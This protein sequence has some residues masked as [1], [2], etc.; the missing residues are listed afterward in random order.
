MNYSSFRYYYPPRPETVVP[1]ASLPLFENKGYIWQ[2]KLNGSCALIFTNGKEVRLMSRHKDTFTYNH[3]K[4]EEMLLLQR[5]GWTVLAGE[6]MNKGQKGFDGKVFNLKFVIWD[7]LVHSGTYLIGTT[8][9]YR[10]E[11]IDTLYPSTPYDGWI[12]KVSENIYKAKCFTTGIAKMYAE[13]IKI[14][15]YE[16][17]VGKKATAKLEMG[18]HA[19]NNRGWM[20][21]C[22]K[23][24]KNYTA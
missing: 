5:N 21:K 13:I 7:I 15:M 24:T 18:M 4:N 3:M 8:V 20:V 22:R 19:N 10:M 17:F 11:L 1:Q 2:P 23:P 16:G 14:G 12:E 6:Y 9:A